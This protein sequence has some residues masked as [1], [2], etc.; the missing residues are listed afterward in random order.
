MCRLG[1]K[2]SLKS[3]DGASHMGLLTDQRLIDEVL[4]IVTGGK[5]KARAGML[6]RNW[7]DT[8]DLLSAA[9]SGGIRRLVA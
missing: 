3:F 4:H 5:S 7:G 6:Q 9:I 2:V 8:S 1:N